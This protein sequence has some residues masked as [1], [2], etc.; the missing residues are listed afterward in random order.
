MYA[1]YFRRQNSSSISL[2]WT[3]LIN[4]IS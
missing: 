2:S 4:L 1:L 3:I